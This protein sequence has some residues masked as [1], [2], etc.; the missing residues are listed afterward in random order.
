M[1]KEKGVL[2]AA[3]GADMASFT[4]PMT[5]ALREEGYQVDTKDLMD[6]NPIND[7]YAFSVVYGLNA[8]V[9]RK[10]IEIIQQ[11]TPN[12]IFV[13]ALG[14]FQLDETL[15]GVDRFHLDFQS[16]TDLVNYIKIT[17]PLQ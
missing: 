17:Y 4:R 5:D 11:S 15:D 16:I 7:N 10:Q 6:E 13:S 14:F 9:F 3:S 2:V 8:S 12:V 1:D